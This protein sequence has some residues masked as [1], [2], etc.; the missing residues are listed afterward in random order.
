MGP[1]APTRLP[2]LEGAPI[3]AES[4]AWGW[5][6]GHAAMSPTAKSHG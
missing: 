4:V 5:A 3:G 1:S 6:P 2:D